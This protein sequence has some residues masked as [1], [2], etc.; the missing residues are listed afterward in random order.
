M[1]MDMIRLPE[2]VSLDDWMRKS[3]SYH[4]IDFTE[5][6][7]DFFSKFTKENSPFYSFKLFGS[8]F[9][10]TNISDFVELIRIRIIKLD[11]DWYLIGNYIHGSFNTKLYI[12]DEWEEVIG[13][14]SNYKCDQWFYHEFKI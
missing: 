3:Q 9:F 5:R 13:F 14:L 11:D 10:I 6:E 4:T 2:E 1:E 12:C 8:Y 7:V